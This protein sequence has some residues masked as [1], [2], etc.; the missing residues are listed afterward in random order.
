MCV[1][2]IVMGE[3]GE[4]MRDILD[5]AK[6]DRDLE[7]LYV[8]DLRYVLSALPPGVRW[9]QKDKTFIQKEDWRIEDENSNESS[10]R[11]T[12]RE[13]CHAMNS[14]YK[15]L[16][17]TVEIEEDFENLRLPTLDCELF[18]NRENYK[19]SY[20]F[21][22]KPMKSPFCVMKN[23]A[24]SE[25][26]KMSILSQDLIR[27]MQNTEETI[28]ET[29]RIEIIIDRLLVSGYSPD[30]TREIIESGLKG[31]SRKL[32]RSIR[33]GIPLHRPAASALQGRIKK[34]LTEKSSWYKK[35]PKGIGNK[36]KPKSRHGENNS[37]CRNVPKVISVMFVAKTPG[38]GLA[39]RLKEADNKISEI[40][41]DK[42][43][44]VERS[45]NNLRSLLHRADP[46]DGQ[47]CDNG[48]CL[49]CTNPYNKTFNC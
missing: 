42:L 21:F 27:R 46:W 31:Y 28:S 2:R 35:K 32:S 20:S 10:T 44:F 26:S 33:T 17:F 11:R 22:E 25:K 12:S 5:K 37:P 30:Q 18:M 29:E 23:S 6:I 7:G 45:G 38:S 1:A 16:K 3:W 47:K 40:M 49:I 9:S 41:E 14:V 24:M 48:K 15:S 43:R 36:D 8:D 13:I 19:L 39:N 4:K 34:N